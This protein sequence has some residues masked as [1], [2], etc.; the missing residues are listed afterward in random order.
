MNVLSEDLPNVATFLWFLFNK[1]TEIFFEIAAY[2]ELFANLV[3]YPHHLRC[4][5][6]NERQVAS[7]SMLMQGR[8]G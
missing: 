6:F 1:T 8:L 4:L 7:F 3:L 2:G 5:R